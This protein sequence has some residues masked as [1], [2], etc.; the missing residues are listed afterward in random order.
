M[1]PVGDIKRTSDTKIANFNQVQEGLKFPLKR[2]N[3]DIKFISHILDKMGEQLRMQ[4]GRG[5]N[6]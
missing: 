1:G 4:V 5:T 3:K 2:M 6:I